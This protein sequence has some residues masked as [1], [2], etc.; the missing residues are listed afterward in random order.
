MAGGWTE[1]QL[2]EIIVGS[3][4]LCPVCAQKSRDKSTRKLVLVGITLVALVG[5]IA[6][7]IIH[8][9]V[10]GRASSAAAGPSLNGTYRIVRDDTKR[11]TNG[12][13][14]PST[15]APSTSP[16]SDWA[17]R[18]VCSRTG[19]VATGTQL[20]SAN[21]K[22]PASP[23]STSVLYFTDGYWRETFTPD[24]VQ[25]AHTECL[26]FDG[27]GPG[28]ETRS[29]TRTLE[30]QPDGALRGVQT[31]TVLTNECGGQGGVLQNPVVAT[32]TGEVPA[33]VTVADP[34]DLPLAPPPTSMSAQPAGSPV[35]DGTYRVEFDAS[36]ETVNGIRTPGGTTQPGWWAFRSLCTDKRCIATGAHLSANNQHEPTGEFLVF[37]FAD[38]RWQDTPYLRP[39]ED[40]PQGRGTQT[41]TSSLSAA[42]QPDG[43][44]RG[45][46]TQTVLT[47][48]CGLQGYVYKVPTVLTRVGDVSPAVVLADPALFM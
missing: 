13:L 19:C 30:P 25:V 46:G 16:I 14:I 7:V 28:T 22:N 8:G 12:A 1:D 23:P 33:G 20:D 10:H 3:M 37:Q 38:G 36:E 34:A 47:N 27:V 18:S 17:F 2:V 31:A 35:L 45:T 40:C 9:A 11:T 44:L 24:R 42:P 39:P 41:L 21:P 32:K 6:A 26:R 5:S 4:K 48:G 43:T 15:G 29:F